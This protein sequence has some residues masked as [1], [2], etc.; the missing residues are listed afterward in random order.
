[1]SRLELL[2]ELAAFILAKHSGQPLLVAIDGMDTSGKSRLSADLAGILKES[3]RQILTVSLDGFHHPKKIRYRQGEFSALGCY[4]DSFNLPALIDLVLDP[5]IPGGSRK[6]KRRIF[7]YIMD[8]PVRSNWK[9]VSEDSILLLDGL[10]LQRHELN[11]Y[12]DVRILLE[13]DPEVSIQR[14]IQRDLFYYGREETVRRK[15]LKCYLPAYQLYRKRCHPQKHAD[16]VIE[17][18]NWREPVVRFQKTIA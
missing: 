8:Q 2:K 17:N 10:Y 1:M 5:L 4:E 14:A 12:W 15:Y 9:S 7:D 16:V 3:Q 18:S 11:H 6:I 13:I